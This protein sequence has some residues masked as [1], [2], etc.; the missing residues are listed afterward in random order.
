MAR[1]GTLPASATVWHSG[2]AEW[3]PLAEFLTQQPAA[4]LEAP[5]REAPR[6]NAGELRA[7]VI[8]REHAQLD[9][10]GAQGQRNL[11]RALGAGF[12]VALLGAVLWWLQG[13]ATKGLL[14]PGPGVLIGMGV[15]AV[16]G[17][18]GKG[19]GSALLPAA[20]MVFTLGAHLI[21]G[22]SLNS[23]TLFLLPMAL[24]MAWKLSY[25]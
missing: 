5:A 23:L 17:K 4:T 1:I 9:E 22:V 21:V 10:L 11:F 7:L 14:I 13:R 19:E 16:I 24:F 2:A 20:A 18:F 3:Y 25:L 15:G 8:A 12:G 6:P